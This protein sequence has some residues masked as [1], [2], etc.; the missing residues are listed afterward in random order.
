MN[1][2]TFFKTAGLA[3]LA[4]AA[5]GTSRAESGPELATLLDLSRCVGC[6]A[7]VD[8]CREANADRF[9]QP[10]KPFPDMVPDRVPVEDFSDRRGVR[11]RLTPYNWLYIQTARVEYEGRE[12]TIH[13]PR[14]CMHCRNAPCAA[15]C[16]WGA[17]VRRANGAV[18]IDDDICLG[19]AKCRKVCPW[20]IPQRQTGVG[21][22]LDIAPR[23]AGN[24]AMFKCDRCQPR[25]EQGETPACI[26]ACPQNV[27]SIG[28]REEMAARARE[29]AQEM[30]G[31]VFGDEE[32]GGTNTFYVSPVPFEL[33]NEAVETG[34]GRPH[35]GGVEDVMAGD[36]NLVK[37]ALAAPV[38][39]V[40]AAALRLAG[41]FGRRGGSQSEDTHE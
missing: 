28:P 21:L 12:W 38:A 29:L 30:G 36:E 5:P 39:G 6:G 26:Q 3:G 33:L 35:L 25:M 10:E 4:A 34:P 20:S 15:M 22:Y 18:V 40:A 32:N 7:C 2:R 8:A 13:V 17:A 16:P 9:P 11:D 41:V 24:G 19:G 1:R 31:F 27:Q 14:R 37:A 23:F